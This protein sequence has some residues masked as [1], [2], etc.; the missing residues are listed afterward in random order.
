MAGGLH[1]LDMIKHL[2][3]NT[4]LRKM[5]YFQKGN[6]KPSEIR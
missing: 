4:N 2:R 5:N 1:G 3:N 6:V